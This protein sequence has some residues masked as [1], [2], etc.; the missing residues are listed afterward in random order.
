MEGSRRHRD[1]S[2][3]HAALLT[4]AG[5]GMLKIIGIPASATIIQTFLDED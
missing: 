4:N 3:F 2:R 1:R 5:G